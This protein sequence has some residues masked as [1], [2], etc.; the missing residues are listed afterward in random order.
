MRLCN[1][2]DKKIF[3]ICIDFD[4]NP[5]SRLLLHQNKQEYDLYLTKP[6]LNT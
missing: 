4:M 5:S 2:C 3:V 1:A 6:C